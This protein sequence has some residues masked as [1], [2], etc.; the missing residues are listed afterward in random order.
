[1][2]LNEQREQ[3]PEA[4]CVEAEGPEMHCPPVLWSGSRTLVHALGAVHSPPLR[5]VEG[6]VVGRGA[7]AEGELRLGRE[8]GVGAARAAGAE[9]KGELR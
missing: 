4:N 5:E 7:D 9:A 3:T 6:V 2:E 1:M 8:S